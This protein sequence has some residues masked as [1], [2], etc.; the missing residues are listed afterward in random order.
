VN[1]DADQVIV[2]SANRQPSGLPSISYFSGSLESIKLDADTGQTIRERVCQ[3]LE[4]GREAF[5]MRERKY[6]FDEYIL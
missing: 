3:L 4:G 6:R 2:A 1:T 5:D